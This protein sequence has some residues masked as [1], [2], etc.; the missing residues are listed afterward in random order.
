[1]RHT[2]TK[3]MNINIIGGAETMSQRQ[4]V[5]KT[6]CSIMY[7]LVL[8]VHWCMFMN[9]YVCI[10]FSCGYLYVDIVCRHC[11]YACM[12]A[13]TC[14]LCIYICTYVCMCVC[15]C[16]HKSIYAVCTYVCVACVLYIYDTIYYILN[17]SCDSHMAG[18]REL[19]MFK[20]QCSLG[21]IICH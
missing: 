6:A 16:V 17:L 11:M 13:C 10:C 14:I 15:M 20:S 12:Y 19:V 3:Q 5:L 7:Y 8:Y 1:M 18:R 9:V 4:K 2:P 21:I